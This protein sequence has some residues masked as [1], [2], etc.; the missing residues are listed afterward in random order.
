VALRRVI[1]G[2]L[3]LTIYPRSFAPVDDPIKGLMGT[4]PHK[5]SDKADYPQRPLASDEEDSDE[6]C[7]R[8]EEQ[9]PAGE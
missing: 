8:E 7:Q 9:A 5:K 3:N 2:L 1:Y 4:P 6:K